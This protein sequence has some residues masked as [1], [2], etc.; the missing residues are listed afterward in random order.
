MQSDRYDEH[1]RWL[2]GLVLGKCNPLA[3]DVPG[4][5]VVLRAQAQAASD[6]GMLDLLRRA[7]DVHVSA[8]QAADVA[9][10]QCLVDGDA[11]YFDDR[12]YERLE[13][14]H[15][16]YKG[17]AT[18]EALFDAAVK[19]YADAVVAAAEWCLAGFQADE[20]IERASKLF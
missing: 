4:R 8:Q 6:A 20:V 2:A 17:N 7:A 19:A 10:L 9:F 14:L 5:L 18:I 15:G 13:W 16:K 11:D 12:L 3:D 1:G